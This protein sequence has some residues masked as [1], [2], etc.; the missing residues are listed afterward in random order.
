MPAQA[1]EFGILAITEVDLMHRPTGTASAISK[2]R[3]K[4]IVRRYCGSE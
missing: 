3:F 2:H 1:K 4:A